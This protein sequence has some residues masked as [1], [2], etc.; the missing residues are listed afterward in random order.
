MANLS[1]GDVFFQMLIILWFSSILSSA[2]DNI[3]ITKVLIPVI[4]TIAGNFPSNI[5]NQFYYSL[6]IGANWGDNLTPMGDNILVV[7]LAE[8]N[9][10]PISFKQFFKIGFI[11]TLYQLTIISIYY[12]LIFSTSLGILII[13]IIFISLLAIYLLSKLGP[14]KLRKKISSIIN[15]FRKIFT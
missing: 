8:S 11:T 5:G 4:G 9:K 15:G 10:R 12:T 6:A 14:K 3:P 2:I 1:G 13:I 7:Q